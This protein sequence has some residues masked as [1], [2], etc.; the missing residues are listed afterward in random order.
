M[1]TPN[2]QGFFPDTPTDPG[3]GG[4]PPTTVDGI[5]QDEANPAMAEVH[6]SDGRVETMPTETANTLPSTPPSPAFDPMTLSDGR[7]GP[8]PPGQTPL[9]GSS[10]AG[11]GGAAGAAGAVGIDY[12]GMIAG[13]HGAAAPSAAPGLEQVPLGPGSTPTGAPT[14]PDPLSTIVGPG[15]AATPG[16]KEGQDVTQSQTVES[17]EAMAAR[18]DAAYDAEAVATHDLDARTQAG[19]AAKANT[20]QS[21]YAA[22]QKQL[23]E[24]IVAKTAALQAEHENILKSVEATPVDPDDF[25]TGHPARQAGAWIALALSG[26]LQGATQGAN[27]ALAQMTQAL[28]HAQ[29]EYVRTQQA[30]R[31]SKLKM[32]ERLMGDSENALHTMRIQLSGLMD[33]RILADAQRAGIQPT[34][35]MSTYLAKSAVKRA[36]AQNKIGERVD[37]TVT[38]RLEESRKAS[39]ATGPVRQF[40]VQLQQLGVDPKEHADAMNPKKLN[41]GGVV[42][43]GDRLQ[44]I[45]KTLQAIA[46]RNDGKL[47]NQDTVSWSSLGMA[48]L[49]ARFGSKSGAD[50]I[51][52]KSLLEEA[53]LAYKQTLGSSR[54]YDS[55]VE[56]KRFD[57]I[58]DTG[59]STTT[60]AEIKTRAELSSKQAVSIASGVAGGAAQQYLQLIRSQQEANPGTRKPGG[61]TILERHPAAD[62]EAGAVG[63]TTDGA[64]GPA[65]SAP[66]AQSPSASA[67]GTP[68]AAAQAGPSPPPSPT[69]PPTPTNKEDAPVKLSTL[70]AIKTQAEAAGLNGD[71]LTRII[72]FESGGR[73]DKPNPASGAIGLIQW[74][75]QF[76]LPKAPGYENV[77][78]EDLKD[79]TAEEQIPLVLQYF[80]EK[81]LP[82]N[83]GV[84]DMYLAVA[85]PGF[86]GKPD[87]RIAYAKGT[88]AWTDNPLWRP[89]D[90]GD[91]T[92]GSIK[93]L[94]RK[95]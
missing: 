36:E 43:G 56:G 38:R 12:E 85:A 71:A 37:Q 70:H 9:D 67:L 33:K 86:L 57:A 41:L 68:T 95:F 91:I 92:V 44:D 54:T 45:S 66:L 64:G 29:D 18:T 62:G 30:S 89:A 39:A 13:L 77:R 5:V 55:D 78:H 31:D 74:M 22:H 24:E 63:A 61:L 14:P 80:K 4:P 26:F 49:A 32:R 17:P 48:S 53:K 7:M 21:E 84:E 76:P 65:P 75:P 10:G 11:D 87:D 20:E 25:W 90:G 27:P 46:A 40:D 69:T 16:T 88:K 1:L 47:P 83:A 2:D 23:E 52:I 81:G 58:M 34:P 28:D 50:Q 35:G 15:A 59:E 72:R 73:P 94:A 8:P 3:P 82:P 42:V 79:L 19:A 51:N 93:A 6:F 60:L